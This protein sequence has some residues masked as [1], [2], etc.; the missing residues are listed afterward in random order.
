MN[1]SE[2]EMSKK[3]KCPMCGRKEAVIDKGDGTY[4]CTHCEMLFDP[5]E[6]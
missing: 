6:D 3:V 5:R 1:N 4:F 2:T